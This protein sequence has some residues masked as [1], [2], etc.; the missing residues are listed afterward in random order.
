[1]IVLAPAAR[2]LPLTVSDAVEAV[3]TTVPSD[4]LPAVKTMLPVGAILPDAGFTVTV[5]CVVPAAAMLAG[6]TETV[7]VVAIGGAVTVT[8]RGA[9][10]EAEKPPAPA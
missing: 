8:V 9:A 2:L 10:A 1:V 4:V 6:F 3:R 7:V 5:N